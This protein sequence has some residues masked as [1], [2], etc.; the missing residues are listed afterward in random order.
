MTSLR[1]LSKDDRLLLVAGVAGLVAAGFLACGDDTETPA[2]TP[3]A[4][5]DSGGEVSTEPADCEQSAGTA[6]NTAAVVAATKT[7]LE[8]LTEAQ[9]T[10][11]T[12]DKTLA[13]AQKWSNFP[14]T[15]VTRN[16]V[17]LGDMSE[18]AEAAAVALAEV[19]AGD[20]GGTL[21]AELREADE[22]LVTD[23]KASTTDYGRGLYYFSVHGTPSTSAA[24]MLQ[25]G[26]HHLAY[27]F[28]YAGKCTSATPLFDGAEPMDWTDGDG[29]VHAPLKAQRDASVALVKSI[30]TL[31][32]AELSGSMS[33]LLNGPAGG[34]PGGGGGGGDTK[35]PAS[36]SYPS[37]TTGR[38]A[39]VSGMSSDQ[40]A[41]VKTAIEAWVKNVAD[42]VSSALLD[43]YESDEALAQTYVGYIGSSDLSERGSYVRID[44]PRVWIEASV[45]GGIIYQNIVHYHTIWRDKVADYGAEYSSQ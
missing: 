23:G 34:G 14:T 24:W 40:R 12:Y 7:F 22:W 3:D 41:L 30:A 28:M 4:S 36:L 9:R 13:N 10:A 27:N 11:A 37:G 45:Q 18:E 8:A 19:A 15:F 38:G 20:T 2:N 1:A 42:P 17:K 21:L 43:E 31:S 29:T 25:I 39:A 26:G 35:Y 6:D 32:G 33:D 44:G 16:G 5:A